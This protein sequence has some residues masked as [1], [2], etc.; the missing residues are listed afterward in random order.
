MSEVSGCLS[1][2]CKSTLFIFSYSRLYQWFCS[3]LWWF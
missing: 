1:Y 2:Q 3:S